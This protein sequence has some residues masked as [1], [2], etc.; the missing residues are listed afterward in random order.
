M[1]LDIIVR[2]LSCEQY[3][4]AKTVLTYVSLDYEIDTIGL[5]NAALANGKRVACPRCEGDKGEMNFYFIE[6]MQDLKKGTFGVLEPMGEQRV[7]SEFFANSICVVPGLGFDA[8]GNRIG[9]GQG[10]YD[11]FLASY[12]GFKIGL[13]YSNCVKYILPFESF[14]VPVDC[15]ITENYIRTVKK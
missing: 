13:C 5:I 3:N 8:L 10:Y 7:G 9:Y 2:L 15:I 1:D 11:R 6:S 14:D 4:K 12:N